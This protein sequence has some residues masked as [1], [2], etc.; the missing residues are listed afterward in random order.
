MPLAPSGT[1]SSPGNLRGK[2]SIS[3]VLARLIIG[4][5]SLL[6]LRWSEARTAYPASI[7]V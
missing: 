1:V 3:W 6:D 5:G 2:I 7:T 4:M